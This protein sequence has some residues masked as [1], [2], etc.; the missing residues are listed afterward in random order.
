MTAASIHRNA[1]ATTAST[2]RR[3][4]IGL[5]LLYILTY[6]VPLG[7]R[8]LLS[9]DEVRYAQIGDLMRRTGDLVVPHFLG[10][11]YFEKP[12]AA[13]WMNAAAQ[14]LLGDNNFSARLACALSAGLSG[15]MVYALARLIW[16][17]ARRA[18]L[19]TLVYL[20][21]LMVFSTGTYISIDAPFT[22]WMTL[23]MLS[24]WWGQQ[25][26]KPY[27]RLLG[28]VGVGVASGIGVM[29][30]GFIALAIPVITLLPWL[31]YQRQ[32]RE[33]FTH[34]ALSVVIAV[35]VVLPWGI[36]VQL[37]DPEFWS[38][39]FWHEHIQRFFS[40]TDAQHASPIYFFIPVVLFGIFPWWGIALRARRAARQDTLPQP[41]GARLYL[42]LWA[43]MPLIFFS[44]ARGKLAPYV[45]PCFPALALLLGHALHVLLS[46]GQCKTLKWNGLLVAVFG[47]IGLLALWAT[48]A[49]LF[50]EPSDATPFL[51]A[52]LCMALIMALGIIAW[53]RPRWA[54]VVALVPA[55]VTWCLPFS[56][57]ADRVYYKMPVVFVEENEA[58]LRDSTTLVSNTISGAA[59]ISWVL[60]RDNIV[61]FDKEGELEFGLKDYPERLLD[62]HELPLWLVAARQH[63]RVTL[64]LDNEGLHGRTPWVFHPDKVAERGRFLLLSFPAT[65]P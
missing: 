23:L 32:W 12:I 27:Q 35:L 5:I 41:H 50:S 8:P 6:L 44:C 34:G 56:M 55:V 63:G 15:L 9:P 14:A 10:L 11:R 53:Y 16:H 30:K 58:I 37:R 65:S 24:F 33:A 22:L 7:W 29:T 20:S 40:H 31:L 47:L 54:I 17:D 39:F 62:Y 1:N 19:C 4:G 48:R 28:Y 60:K 2:A 38:F 21:M 26:D 36:A 61:M 18:A 64:L 46:Q 59:A 42:L 52:L 43:L 25:S 49:Q 45:L 3:D 51:V 13:Y 57:P